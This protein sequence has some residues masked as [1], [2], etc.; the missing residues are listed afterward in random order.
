MKDVTGRRNDH[1]FVKV[2][3]KMRAENCLLDLVL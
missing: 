3:S 1:L 2:I